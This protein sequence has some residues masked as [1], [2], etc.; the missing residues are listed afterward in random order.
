MHG[1]AV[2]THLTG[3]G[4]VHTR[5][6]LDEG[7]LAGD[8]VAQQAVAFAGPDIERDARQRND[9]AEVLLDVLHLQQGL[10]VLCH[11]NVPLS[12]ACE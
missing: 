5:H 11:L 1:L 3:T 4:R 8:V 7:G 10:V 6:G 12:R 9:V 2:D